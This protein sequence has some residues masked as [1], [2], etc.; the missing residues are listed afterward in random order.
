M[1]IHLTPTA[2]ISSSSSFVLLTYIY[3]FTDICVRVKIYY[4]R[5]MH[6]NIIVQYLHTCT[7]SPISTYILINTY[8]HTY[9]YTYIHIHTHI[10][11]Y[12]HIHKHTYTPIHTHAYYTHTY[13]HTH[14][15]TILHAFH[16]HSYTYMHTHIYMYVCMYL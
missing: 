6:Q 7:L 11:T 5:A 8:T 13:V 1:R 4:D 3:V 12:T 9:I 14:T 10:H 16:K 2:P 15:H